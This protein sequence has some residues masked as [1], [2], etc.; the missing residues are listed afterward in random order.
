MNH[1]V[2]LT[3]E[4]LQYGTADAGQITSA[5]RYRAAVEMLQ[6]FGDVLT[7]EEIR[8]EFHQKQLRLKHKGATK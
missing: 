7:G 3:R 6:D 2:E 5:D 8:G 1:K 4:L